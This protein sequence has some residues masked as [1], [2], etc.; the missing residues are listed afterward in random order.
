MQNT[1]YVK[2]YANQQNE[3]VVRATFTNERKI[4]IYH[5]F[6]LQEAERYSKSYNDQLARYLY[7]NDI[8]Q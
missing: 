4:D 8:N 5:G 7:A 6:H 1:K 2:L 3:C